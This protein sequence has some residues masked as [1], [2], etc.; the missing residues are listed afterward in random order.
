MFYPSV[1]HCFGADGN[2]CIVSKGLKLLLFL[3][4]DDKRFVDVHG[5]VEE[6]FVVIT[7]VLMIRAKGSKIRKMISWKVLRLYPSS[8]SQSL[9]R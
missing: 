8:E 3:D 4:V 6:D 5:L 7:M 1:D 2:F 9:A